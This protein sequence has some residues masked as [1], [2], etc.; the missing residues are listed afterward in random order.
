MI[1]DYDVEVDKEEL[2]FIDNIS[3]DT[4]SN[5]ECSN[6]T[7][8]EDSYHRFLEDRAYSLGKRFSNMLHSYKNCYLAKRTT[9]RN[10]PFRTRNKSSP[11]SKNSVK[12]ILDLNLQKKNDKDSEE[13]SSESSYDENDSFEIELKE[14]Q[15]HEI[16]EEEFT[17]YK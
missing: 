13:S 5:E 2:E 11:N 7:S 9:K 16:Y 14:L 3:W 6:D 8:E 4:I 17:R 12:N 1:D 15:E 10:K